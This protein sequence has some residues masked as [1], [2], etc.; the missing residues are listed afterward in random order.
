MDELTLAALINALTM[1]ERIALA[2][3][4]LLEDAGTSAEDVMTLC[5]YAMAWWYRMHNAG[6]ES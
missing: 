2:N 1:V 5:Q 6:A 3:R 4:K